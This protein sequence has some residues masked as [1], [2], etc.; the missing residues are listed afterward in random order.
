MVR[1]LLLGAALGIGTR[2][3]YHGPTELLWLHKVGVPWLAAAFLV[4][5]LRPAVRAGAV[6]GA[7]AL[8]VAVVV[9]YEVPVADSGS[10]IRLGWIWIAVPAGAAYG[11][12]GAAWRNH[13]RWRL[14]ATA[15]LVGAFL[16]EAM[17]W[18]GRDRPHVAVAEYCAAALLLG[19]LLPRA[20]QRLTAAAAAGVI[21][22]AAAA[23]EVAVCVGLGYL[24]R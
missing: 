13:E 19:L 3:V 8:V 22:V 6:H 15:F 2:L 20:S 23:T 4:G 7:L 17:I 1:S 21:A 5:A 12:L 16:G 18:Y 24:S 11:A 14:A 10:H 9:Y